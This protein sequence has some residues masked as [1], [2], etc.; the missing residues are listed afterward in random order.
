[1]FGCTYLDPKK[2]KF[3]DFASWYLDLG[4]WKNYFQ[5]RKFEPKK[6]GSGLSVWHVAWKLNIAL[7]WLYIHR[8]RPTKK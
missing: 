8:D 3:R 7:K 2:P 5:I 1:M 4:L 6:Q